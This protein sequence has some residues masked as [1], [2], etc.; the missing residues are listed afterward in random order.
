M[1][2]DIPGLVRFLFDNL[3]GG[4]ADT[5]IVCVGDYSEK[6]PPGYRHSSD[7]LYDMRYKESTT[8]VEFAHAVNRSFESCNPENAKAFQKEYSHLFEQY[9]P[10]DGHYA[11]LN[12]T[13]REYVV[14]KGLWG[15][16]LGEDL[17]GKTPTLGD[18]AMT[19]ICW[20]QDAS[21]SMKY[22]MET[23]GKWACHRFVI[24]SM[25]LFDS[26]GWKDVSADVYDVLSG[27]WKVQFGE[28]LSPFDLA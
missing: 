7:S 16:E 10:L 4:W 23:E 5:A 22:P 24:V 25:S 28:Q 17:R 20:S 2:D 19:G 8:L 26:K 15:R 3:L 27:I 12:L 9:F 14:S 11:L 6:L 21:T 18:A 13:S 1:E